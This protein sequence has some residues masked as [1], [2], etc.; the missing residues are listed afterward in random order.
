MSDPHQPPSSQPAPSE[1]SA[2]KVTLAHLRENCEP[3][4]ESRPIPLPLMVGFF[5]L[6]AWGGF[7][8]ATY[9]AGW[10]VDVY[11]PNWSPGGSAAATQEVVF[12]PIKAGA[13]LFTNNCQACHQA[14]GQ[15]VP[16]AF[17]PLAGSRWV[18]DDDGTRMAKILLRG[19]QG[20]IE[21]KG[22]QFDGNMPSYG[23][24]GLN[25]N[26]RNIAAV[27]TWV[28][29]AWDNGAEAVSEE[30]VA[31]VRAEIASQ[32]GTWQGADIMKAHPLQ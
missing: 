6:F 21:V 20:P 5:L 3:H 1:E 8:L 11:D 26:D 2:K 16:G 15:G 13:R 24:N 9:H 4:E 32:S 25:W 10:R 17:P 23:E 30:H 18:T 22:N 31:K 12:D 14:N 27:L 19:M 28:R 29:Q 7:Y